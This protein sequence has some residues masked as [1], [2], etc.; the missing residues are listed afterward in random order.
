[1]PT[2]YQIEQAAGI[3]DDLIASHIMKRQT[4]AARSAYD[5]LKI[6]TSAYDPGGFELLKQ[7][8]NDCRSEIST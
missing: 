6:Q 5:L 4:T 1:M 2:Q 8:V 3:T 7:A